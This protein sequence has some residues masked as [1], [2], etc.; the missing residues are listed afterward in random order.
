MMQMQIAGLFTCEDRDKETALKRD[1]RLCADVGEYCSGK[2]AF[3]RTCIE[4]THT[5]CCFNSRLARLINEPKRLRL[6]ER[7]SRRYRNA[8]RE[9]A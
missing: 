4:R 3:I 6:Y 8:L 2:L 9:L 7:F 1:Q 5:Y